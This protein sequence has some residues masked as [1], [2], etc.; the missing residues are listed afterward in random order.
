MASSLIETLAQAQL[1]AYN[2]RDLNAF[3]ACYHGDVAVYDEDELSVSGLEEF[4]Q[5]LRRIIQWTSF[6]CRV[7]ER[8]VLGSHCVDLEHWW[9]ASSDD[10][11]MN[12]G[13]VLVRYR[14]KDQRIGLVQFLKP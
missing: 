13:T 5:Q 7:E 3:V 1:D 6:R 4:R 12:R 2:R 10:G 11:G 9:R 8:V 14:L